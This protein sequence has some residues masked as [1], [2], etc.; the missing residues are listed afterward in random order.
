MSPDGPVPMD[1]AFR[2][3]LDMAANRF[4]A[5]GKRVLGLAYAPLQASYYQQSKDDDAAFTDAVEDIIR[6]QIKVFEDW[7]RASEADCRNGNGNDSAGGKGDDNGGDRGSGHASLG[8]TRPMRGTQS[9]HKK[10]KVMA[11]FCFLGLIMLRDPPRPRARRAVQ[12]C[13]EA[14]IQVVMITGD[15]PITA[16]A[17]AVQVGVIPHMP[18]APCT[19]ESLAD[20]ARQRRSSTAAG[21]DIEQGQQTSQQQQPSTFND[22][23]L[24]VP[25]YIL[26]DMTHLHWSVVTASR[27]VVFARTTPEDKLLVVKMFAGDVSGK[28]RVIGMTGDG[29]NDSP[30]LKEAAVGIAMGTGSDV[31]KEAADMVILDDNFESIVI[32]IR[33]GRLLFTNLKKSIAYTLAHLMPELLPVVLWAIVGVPLAISGILTLCIDLL[34]EV[35][36][37]TSL[38]YEPAKSDLMS[39]PPRD[40]SSDKLVDARLL[41]YSYLEAG[42]LITG[43]CLF[44]MLFT[45]D[46]YGVSAYNVFANDNQ[47]FPSTDGSSVA[48]LSPDEQKEVLASVQ[49]TWFLTLVIA[50][51]CHSFTCRT[52]VVSIFTHGLFSNPYL[53]GGSAAAVAIACFIIYTPGLQDVVATG[54]ID[55][56][57]MLYAVSPSPPPPLPPPVSVIIIPTLTL[58]ILQL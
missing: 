47:H 3:R 26:Q 22:E 10:N 15:H 20:L 19:L 32:G 38:A 25:G 35:L 56:L 44:T 52:R 43:V 23:P 1:Q 16:A 2:D 7:D 8:V 48:G 30:A 24:V 5:Q 57:L 55:S 28:K 54:E 41:F 6:G 51:A 18:R 4:A 31:S 12:E 14:G 42:T 34:T 39:V 49:A 37:A 53:V 17:I 11:E 13:Q 46:S 9:P 45:Y 21:G 27:Q 29:V 58:P 40:L 33:E 50:Q 36:P